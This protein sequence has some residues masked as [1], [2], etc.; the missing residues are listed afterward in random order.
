MIPSLFFSLNSFTKKEEREVQ[1]SLHIENQIEFKDCDL[2]GTV[3]ESLSE[4]QEQD[5]SFLLPQVSLKVPL[6]FYDGSDDLI[7]NWVGT[8]DFVLNHVDWP[9]KQQ[10]YDADNATWSLP[11]PMGSKVAGFYLKSG[12]VMLS[13]ILDAGFILSP[14]FTFSLL[15]HIYQS[16]DT[17]HLS[18]G[19]KKRC[20]SSTLS[21]L[22]DG[23]TLEHFKVPI[24]FSH[25]FL[26][27]TFQKKES[28]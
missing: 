26:F 3:F 12:N 28:N 16:Q 17:Q 21:S 6:L 19:D 13:R 1:R 23:K 25:P 20:S 5:A 9:N 24:S 18:T 4:D 27:D 22:E 15:I 11:I 7:C 14:N 2:T 10:L 8:Y